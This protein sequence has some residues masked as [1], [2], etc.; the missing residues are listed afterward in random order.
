M[1]GYLSL[2]LDEESSE[3]TTFATPIGRFKFRRMP[4]GLISA[5]D[6]FQ[7]RMEEAFEGVPE[8]SVI[9]D[10]IIIS[11][12]SETELDVN[13]RAA[14]TRASEWTVKLNKA[15]CILKSESIP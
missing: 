12:K 5:Q 10:D 7:R 6:E 11:G 13:T 2:V 8:F 3:L 4:F 14:L 15:K 9:V 1:H